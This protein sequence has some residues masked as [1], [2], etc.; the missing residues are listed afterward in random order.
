MTYDRSGAE[1]RLYFDG[2]QRA[3]YN[4]GDSEGFDFRNDRPLTVG[5]TGSDA[6]PGGPTIKGGAENLQRLVDAFNALGAD[7]VQ[8]EELV[9]LIS[10]PKTLLERKA[11]EKGARL[12]AGGAA[13]VESMRSADLGN[14]KKAESAL[15]KSP[16]TVHQNRKFT[17]IAP[18]SELYTLIGDRVMIR[19]DG[20]LAVARSRTLGSTRFRR[21]RTRGVES[22]A[23]GR[24]HA[25]LLRSTLR[26]GAR[27]ARRE[28]FT[29]HVRVLEHL[30]RGQ[31]LH[32]GEGRLG[33]ASDNRGDDPPR[34][35]D[36]VM[37]QETYSHGDFIAA[38]LG[39]YFAAGID[40]DYI[41]QGA[42]I[43][44]LSRYPIEELY[45]PPGSTFNN[46]GVKVALSKT[47]SMYVMSNWYGMNQFP[48]VYEFHE[49]RFKESDI[50]PTL[51]GGDF[52][53]IPHIDGGKS[54]ASVKLLDSGFTDAYRSLHPDHV[55]HPGAS[56]RSG[57]R[58]DQLF[59]KGSG[60]RNTSTRVVSTWPT[61]FPS[62]H[63]MVIASFD[64][65]GASDKKK[66]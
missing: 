38:E 49:N 22:R 12:G 9:D 5:W 18:V 1:I 53:A 24:R 10:D 36:L 35:R 33:L 3:I 19:E 47:Q 30:A 17:S 28:D 54:P 40:W 4:I 59:F 29:D 16:Y 39:Y 57:R 62:D 65:G 15:M 32:R 61:G 45:V 11:R 63:Y 44:V 14:I 7:R 52:N 55:K 37:M 13:F 46:V 58:I 50:T 23:V 31:A 34:G 64:L 25:A 8:P 27:E 43:S 20:A 66:E 56:H 60:L 2:I 26:I 41:N 48:A 6:D 51:F 42:N 21:R